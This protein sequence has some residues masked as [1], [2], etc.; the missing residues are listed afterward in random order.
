[1]KYFYSTLVLIL[2]VTCIVNAQ[3]KSNAEWIWMGANKDAT[4]Y[5]VQADFQ[6]YWKGKKGGKGTGYKVFKRWENMMKPRVYPTGDMNLPS[7]NYQKYMQWK[8]RNIDKFE[9]ASTRAGDWSEVGPL[10][11]PSGY[12]AGVGRVDFL[13]FHPTDDNILYVSTPDGGLWKTNNANDPSPTWTTNNDFISVIGCSDLA[14]HPITPSTMYLATGSWESDKKSVGIIKT[15]NGGAT[16]ENTSLTFAISDAFAIRRLIMDPTN[17]LIMIAATDGGVYRT[18]DGWATHSITSLT[19]DYNIQDIAFKP[20]DH[21]TMYATGQS[22]NSNDM[23]WKS[24]NNGVTWTAVTSGLPSSVLTSRTVMATTAADANY[25]YLLVG[26]TDGGY[27]GMYRSTDGGTTFSTRSTSPNILN[28]NVPPTDNSGQATHD[29]AIVVSP[30]NVDSIVIGGINQYRSVDGGAT[31]SILT[32]WYGTDPSNAGGTPNIAPYLHADVQSISYYPGSSNVLYS[33]CDG[34]ISR[35][36]DNG[37]T[38]LDISNNLRIAQQTDVGLASDDGIMITGLQDIGTIKNTG[39]TWIYVGGGDGES[40]FVDQSDNQNIVFSDPNGAHSFSDNAGTNYTNLTSNGLPAGTEFFSPIIQDPN[41]STTC[42]AGGRPALYKST[43][44]Q[45][46]F[47][48]THSWTSIGTPAG[49]GSILR[50]VVAPS[51]SNVIYTIKEDAVSKT[52]NGGANWTDVSSNLPLGDA[53]LSNI[54]ISNTDTD[55]VWVTYSGYETSDKVYKT[56]NGGTTWTD[57]YSSGLPN[58]P[59]NTIVYRNDDTDDAIY[60]GADIGIYYIDNTNTSW[61]PYHNNM[62]NTKVTDLEI[63]YPTLKLRAAT[64]GRGLWESDLYNA[65]TD[66]STIVTNTLDKG[67]G[68]LRRAIA[69]VADGGTVTF[70][71]TLTDGIG[72]DTIALTSGAIKISKN[73]NIT[74]TAGTVAKIKAVGA[75]GPIFNIAGSQAL[76]LTYIDLFSG[77]NLNNRALLNNGKLIL[78]NINIHEK[79]NTIGTGTTFTNL[80]DFESKGTVQIVVD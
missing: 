41:S 63:Y 15:T 53:M 23:F 44:Y 67:L 21:M 25:V 79:S 80:G 62:A 77:T 48:E 26:N 72:N 36:F 8:R 20:L 45:E 39:G 78:E 16:W 32:Y 38:W 51:N 64:Y 17:P 3:K 58:L 2:S 66:C 30:T 6:K 69:C 55:K 71:S 46:A 49:T 37:L 33:T 1:M 61:Q 40:N 18:T 56:V 42:Y 35:S 31:W 13:K 28:S 73:V 4:F 47:E 11:K 22:G 9:N 14:I 10:S 12:D 74:Q 76:S 43:N 57:V 29:L 24:T 59:I 50:F 5:D 27:L 68:S 65:N 75:T 54:A 34:G 52:I 7:S 60:I 19:L 70:H